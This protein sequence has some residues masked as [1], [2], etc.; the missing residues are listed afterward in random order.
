MKSSKSTLAVAVLLSVMSTGAFAAEQADKTYYFDEVVVT[1]S[2]RP[3]TLFT[4]KSNTQVITAEQI[5]N[6]HYK[7]IEEAVKNIS[8]VQINNYGVAGSSN[9]NG[10]RING[11]NKVVVMI[12]GVRSSILGAE[13]TVLN[14]IMKDMDAIERIEVVKG[15]ASVLYG[16]DAVG[17]VINIITKKPENFKTVVGIEGGSFNHETYNVMTQGKFDKTSYRLFV[18]K[19]HDGDYK[20]GHGDTVKSRQNG[21]NID[22]K[23]M[24]EFSKGN[25]ISMTYRH[26]DE[27]F[28]YQNH[29]GMGG[30]GEIET[31]EFKLD[32]FNITADNALG[33]KLTN[34]FVY[35]YKKLKNG[36]DDG[37][38]H[39]FVPAGY[40]WAYAYESNNIKDVFN[41]SNKDNTLSV[42]IDYVKS[43]TIDYN[44]YYHTYEFWGT[45]YECAKV[46]SGKYIE[47]KSIFIQDNWKFGKGWDLTAGIRLD[48]AKTSSLDIDKNWSKSLNLGYEFSP[49]SNMYIGYNDYFVLPS[50]GQLYNSR[51]GNEQLDAA[52]GKNYEIGFNHKFTDNDVV[53]MHLFRR[54][55][56][57]TI[58]YDGYMGSYTKYVNRDTKTL[59]KGFDIQYDKTFDAHWHAKLSWAILSTEEE[60]QG[61]LPKQQYTLGIDY[62]ADKWNVGLDLKAF[63]G[64]NG[65]GAMGM[66][67]T[68]Y[69]S[70][71]VDKYDL[72][73][74]S[75]Y[76][77]VD[78]A[79]NY[80][81]TKDIKVYAKVNN[82]FDKFYAEQT[83]VAYG[84]PD[85]WSPMRGRTFIVGMNWNF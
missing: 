53:S 73:P 81:A 47:N 79:V 7:S 20:D 21:S 18:E 27:D 40:G 22:F 36:A 6:M 17:G 42:G 71:W 54:K 2:G 11:S 58:D 29:A 67:M 60:K 76:M 38:G 26:V 1:A 16:S 15:S 13:N 3:E 66:D 35:D 55:A 34:K 30:G 64:R 14:E 5:E 57:K 41:Y 85:D 65:D 25:E 8:G 72:F 23:L 51:Y 82:L 62:T 12:D 78:L 44:K 28:S 32:N 49:K 9:T 56:D 50:M 84:N 46:E 75:K 80:K 48:D 45:S 43:K 59:T 19:Y 33:N 74:T 52:K 10:F 31:G 39:G 37:I 24:H 68:T 70:R 77:L 61:Y 83:N 63:A 69:A 4:S